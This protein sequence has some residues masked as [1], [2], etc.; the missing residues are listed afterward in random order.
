MIYVH[1][2]DLIHRDLKSVNIMIAEGMRGKVADYGESRIEDTSQTMTSRG[3][4]LWMAPEVACETRYDSQADVYSF[5]II[6]YEVLKRDLPFSERTDVNAVG[7]AVEVA[8]DGLRP[9]IEDEWHPELK[10]LLKECYEVVPSDRPTFSQLEAR[11]RRVME[12]IR[13]GEKT[14]AA[15]AAAAT[16]GLR[17]AADAERS[18]NF[19]G[20]GLWR[21]IK[22]N[23]QELSKEDQIGRVSYVFV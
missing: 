21:T 14:A 23:W 18:G 19:L 10:S 20:L 17:T 2:A 9:T 22:I 16:V 7:L 13:A 1:S 5:G 11:L 12:D 4:P 15:A 8:L 6:L 3:T